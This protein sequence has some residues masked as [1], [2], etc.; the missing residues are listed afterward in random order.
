[1]L[2][3]SNIEIFLKK[4][5]K[6]SIHMVVNGIKKI[7]KEYR[8]KQNARNEDQLNIKHVLLYHGRIGM[9]ICI[10]EEKMKQV[11]IKTMCN[12]NPIIENKICNTSNDI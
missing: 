7:M 9:F 10:E 12:K 5:K 1:M 2:L 8:K 4:K 3:G 11:Q 6:R